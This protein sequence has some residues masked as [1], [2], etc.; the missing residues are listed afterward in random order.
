MKSRLVIALFGVL[1]FILIGIPVGDLRAEDTRMLL[2]L[3][4]EWKFQTGD[5]VR[6]ADPEF[7][8][9]KWSEIHVPSQ[10]EDEG[11]EDYD[12][13]A[14]YRI[15]FTVSDKWLSKDLLLDLGS[16]DD[17][18]EVFV[19][20]QSIGSTGSFPP[21]YSTAYNVQ[22]RY[23]V[24][25]DILKSGDNNV[26]AIR[27]YDDEQVGGITNGRI[28]LYERRDVLHSDVAFPSVWKFK[29]GDN[30]EWKEVQ[31]DDKNWK[32]IRVP[33]NWER[34]GYKDYDGYAWYRIAFTVPD[35]LQDHNLILLVGKIDDFDETY[36]NGERIG[37][38]GPMPKRRLHSSD[39][40]EYSRL[41]A[42]SIPSGL[43]QFGKENILAIRVYDCWQ[44]GG[45]YEGPIGIVDREQYRKYK[46]TS[47]NVDNWFRELFD[48]FFN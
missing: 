29:T 48:E 38:T 8:D 17:V 13:Y 37:R 24:P 47:R 33:G 42:Y 25:P 16:I 32:D 22:R 9:S 7:D 34:Q 12:G 26:I 36:L 43:L 30:K 11:Y 4:G 2:D 3:R 27:V 14:W 6:W 40:D 31:C 18:D 19:N 45:I 5:E 10:W 1:L 28:G 41:R 20:G 23:P 35:D 44:W 46:R 39:S 21:D 15:H